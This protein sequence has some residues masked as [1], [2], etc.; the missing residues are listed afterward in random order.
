MIPIMFTYV[1]RIPHLIKLA[2]TVLALGV[3][4]YF[5][6]DYNPEGYEFSIFSTE[7]FG[8]DE[9]FADVSKYN[10]IPLSCLCFI[11]VLVYIALYMLCLI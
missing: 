2:S 5:I 1:V 6:V 7:Y 8:Y 9:I 4:Y 3:L 10:F 11:K